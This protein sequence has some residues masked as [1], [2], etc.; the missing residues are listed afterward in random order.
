MKTDRE[1]TTLDEAN[2]QRLLALVG[3]I[4]GVVLELDGDTRYLN[5]WA[6]DPAMLAVPREYA[7]GRTVVEALGPTA[8]APLAALV[9]RV[10][11][12]GVT[13]SIEYPISIR[14][15]D[16]WFFYDIK[17]V[18]AG[19]AMTVV[20]FGRDI[21]ERKQ[22]EE[23]LRA[24]E[25]R[26]R[27]AA[28][29]TNDVLFDWHVPSGAVT[30]GPNAGAVFLAPEL[31]SHV[32]GWKKRIHPDDYDR[33]I[34]SLEAAL[35]SDDA[36]WSSAYRFRRG[37]GSFADVFDRGFI[38]RD[39]G[40]AVRMVGSMADVT[41]LNRL[42]AQ[43][44]QA[45]RLA[46]LGTLAAGVGHEINNPLAYVLGNIEVALDA[47]SLARTDDER[48]EEDETKDALR[49]AKD[50]AL[51]IAEIVKSLKLFSR[52]DTTATKPIEVADVIERSLKMAE[53]ETR[54][55]ARVVR[56]FESDVP[57]VSVSESR[58]GQVC[59]N[60]IVNAAQAIPMGD[61]EGNEI[62]L[63]NGVDERGRV[64]FSVSDSGGGILPEHVGRIFDPFF[65]TKPLGVG[66]GIG[67]SVSLNIVRSMGGDLTVTSRPGERTV[68]TVSLPAEP[69][70]NLGPRSVKPA[71]APLRSRSRVL[72]I[73]DE[74]AI[75][76][77]IGRLLRDECD[78]VTVSRGSEALAKIDAGEPFDIIL[79]DVM[80]PEMTGMDVYARL[81]ERDPSY[82]DRIHFM[83][84][85]AFTPEAARFIESLARPPLM[86]PID[87][88]KL[89]SMLGP[90]TAE[91][92]E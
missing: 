16:H 2:D 86:K 32:D 14:G 51:R 78:V 37:D 84:G 47:P 34:G 71:P 40:H 42:Q 19:D 60:L 58:L 72:V 75:A 69:G 35:A 11:A 74:I 43:L 5:V 27:L 28:Q 4:Q 90:V 57:R 20:V 30:W 21:S 22:A 88:T 59:L 92:A 52:D 25:E 63:S 79:C 87:R 91:A 55:R 12:S 23:A 66:T 29:A 45:D 9:K 15:K 36:S 82:K 31:E 1:R 24:S 44:V 8:G 83:T 70:A 89:R 38:V 68:F 50:G 76:R 10:Y 48:A 3:C 62:V 73:D 77:C 13:E 81:L 7:L 65:T 61:V 64:F 46:S 26:Y 6:D 54:H 41:Q 49:D 53:N 67:L 33:V 18:R 17:R 80:M 85:G 56:R 39:Q